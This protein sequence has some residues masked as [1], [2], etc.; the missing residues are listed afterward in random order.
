MPKQCQYLISLLFFFSVTLLAQGRV[1][2]RNGKNELTVEVYNRT[3][4]PYN[5][6]QGRFSSEHPQWLL[7]QSGTLA[8]LSSYEGEK[9]FRRSRVLLRIP[10][11]VTQPIASGEQEVGLDIL[12][13]NQIISN[14]RLVLGYPPMPGG[15]S[16]KSAPLSELAE[17]ISNREAEPLP[18]KYALRQ[19]Y[20]NPFNPSTTIAFEL[21][22]PV[23][24]SLI[25]YDPLG[26][27]VR[28]LVQEERPA[29]FHTVLWNGKNDS[30]EDVPSAVYFYRLGAG[31]SVMTKKMILI[32]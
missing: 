22:S 32:R 1:D 16:L 9:K 21:P 27:R 11:E 4:Q 30:N 19:N 10:F 24:V 18:T 14:L 28:T 5:S 12:S 26:R 7:P 3:G 17:E 31:S 8:D 25:I 2:V 29:G 6:M 15:T 13:K 23:S 20:P